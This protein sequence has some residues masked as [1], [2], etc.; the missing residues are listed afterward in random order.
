MYCVYLN[1]LDLL[2]HRREL[3]LFQA[4]ELCKQASKYE[5]SPFLGKIELNKKVSTIEAAPS[6]RLNEAREDST[7]ALEVNT[8]EVCVCLFECK[9]ARSAV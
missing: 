8:L 9:H 4:V 3:V 2:R 1:H 5:I 7:H 6:T